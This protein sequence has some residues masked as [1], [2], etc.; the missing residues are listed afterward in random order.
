[1]KK[2]IHFSSTVVYGFKGHRGTKEDA[3]MSPFGNSYCLTKTIAE[4]KLLEYKNK[5]ELI[6]L[7]PS[8]VYGPADLKVTYPLIRSIDRG[9]FGFPNGGKPLTS[10]CYV[11]NLVNATEKALLTACPSG[12]I[13]NISD[14]MDIP[15][16]DFLAMI[17]KKMNSKPPWMSVPSKPL[18]WASVVLENLF[19]MRASKKPPPITPYRIAISSRDYSFSIEKAKEILHYSPPFTT[20]DG[21]KETVEWYNKYMG[22]KLI[23]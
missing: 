11:K 21:I 13:F 18:Y 5:L 17:A 4:K 14:G 12:E 23:S 20:S 19:K 7:R 1:V 2:L 16:K 8:N 15:W 6:I 9:L 22:E 10:L 3:A